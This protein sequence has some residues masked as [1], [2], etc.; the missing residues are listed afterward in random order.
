VLLQ[1]PRSSFHNIHFSPFFPLPSLSNSSLTT[2]FSASPHDRL[3]SPSSPAAVHLIRAYLTRRSLSDRPR[4]PSLALVRPLATSQPPRLRSGSRF[5]PSRDR[6]VPR[7]GDLQHHNVNLLRRDHSQPKP[8]SESILLV[9][10]DCKRDRLYSPRDR[11]RVRSTRCISA[12]KAI[13]TMAGNCLAPPHGPSEK[14]T[15]SNHHN[16]KAIWLSQQ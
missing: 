16:T 5:V 9:K 10:H 12:A 15:Y 4:S 3:F 11:L 7:K 14:T 8:N 6:H 13:L 2:A 1:R